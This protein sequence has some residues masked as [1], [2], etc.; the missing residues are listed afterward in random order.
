MNKAQS[1]KLQTGNPFLDK[2]LSGGFNLG[3]LILLL[4]DEPT[5]LYQSVIKY[6]IAEGCVNHHKVFFYHTNLSIN[7]QILSNLPYQSSQIEAILNSKTKETS[8]EMKIAWR[9]ENIN[10]SNL[11]SDM[12]KSM[13]YVFDLSRKLQPNFIEKNPIESKLI[14]GAKS[15]NQFVLLLSSDYQKY[16][17]KFTEKDSDKYAR[18]IFPNAFEHYSNEIS[19]EEYDEIKAHLIC[20][21]AIGRCLNGTILFTISP[22]LMNDNR[23]IY[24][25][26]LN[27]CDYVLSIKS[28]LM[29]SEK[30]KAGYY[31]GILRF[32]K[33]PSVCTMRPL[34]I[35]TDIYGIL[36][37][38][39]KLVIEKIDIGVEVDRNTKVKSNDIQSSSDNQY[40]F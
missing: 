7:N 32:I 39:R 24:N 11:I 16:S 6:Y 17:A 15:F 22:S 5:K 23:R 31:D 19:S 26:L 10:Y 30:D 40:D 8:E 13:S 9:Y 33:M 12:T 20:L 28:L 37:D 21:K 34:E 29:F 4:E 14:D 38:K 2:I 18:V 35:E 27:T 36:R 1:N 25:L 3:H